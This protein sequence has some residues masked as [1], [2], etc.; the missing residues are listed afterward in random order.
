ME[1]VNV[2]IGTIGVDC[3]VVAP[4][5]LAYA[6]EKAGFKVTCLGAM[7][8][9]EEFIN[10]A[11]ETGARAIL[12]SSHHGHGL[13][14]CEGLRGKCEEAGLDDVLLYVGGFLVVARQ[15]QDWADVEKAYKEIGF[16]R[17]Y[18]PETTPA[19]AIADLRADLGLP[20]E[21]AAN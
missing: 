4:R 14:D 8:A 11:V 17:V 6:F 19:Q 20:V 13:V 18:P 21:V 3:H 1:P 7:C 9:Q 5:V 12:I 10:T 15:R 16:D 2:V